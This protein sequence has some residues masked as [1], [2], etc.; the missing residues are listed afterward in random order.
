[1]PNFSKERFLFY[2]KKYSNILFK[3]AFITSL[4]GMF[5]FIADFGFDKSEYIQK[6]FNTYYFIVIALGI[7]ATIF[8]YLERLKKIKRS[9]IIFDVV[10]ILITLMIL[11]AHFLGVDAHK[12]ISFLYNDNW[13]KFAIILTFIREFSEK[14]INYKSTRLNPAQL[15]IASFL[16]IIFLGTLLLMLPNATYQGISFLDALFTSTSAVCVTGLIVV[17]TGSYF[18]TFGQSIILCLIQAGGIGIL[19]IAS[20]F[21]YF[22]KG[23]ATYENQ[24][25]LGDMTGANKLGEVFS[26]LKRILTI[27]FSIELFA[28]I[29]IYSSLDKNL[30]AS[31]FEKLFFSVFHAVSAFC[32]AGFSTLPNSLY[33]TGF[34]Y[35][36]MLQGI[37]ITAFILGGLGFPIVVNIIKYLKYFVSRKI[38]YFTG[39]KLSHKPWVLNLNSRITLVTTTVLTVVGT[40]LF[41]INEFNNTLAEHKG[42]GKFITA[43]FG[44]AT[45]RTAGF[46]T[47]DMT[48]LNFST[49]MMLFLLMWIGASPASTGGGIKTNTFAIATLNFFSLARGKSKIEVFRREIADISVRR[50]F[51]V[52]ALS[53]LVVGT[54]IIL[55]SIFDSDK[56]LID[57]AF[58][59]FS[60]YS[61]VGLSLGITSSLSSMSKLT[62]I[63]VMFI[64]R[65]SMLTLL[66]AVF[67]KIKHKNYKYP[68][69]ELTIN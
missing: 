49:V 51:A 1:M 26:T 7:I 61:T 43:L 32:N 55:I 12:H 21:S 28:A 62:I 25:T 58:E 19:T 42:V 69:E 45:P 57:I 40:I 9:V 24:L 14:S 39:K 2:N 36:Y 56:S 37:I 53:L 63:A 13:V 3:V 17:D 59:C 35:N 4:I 67:K 68:V 34:R 33:E 46:N 44:A 65:V 6:L 47:V 64:G 5:L 48:A 54:G 16:G 29:L 18:T 22:F 50:A 60:A 10:T 20:Y 8:R 66:I 11:Y 15:F 41:Y 31:F 38:F 27:T 23:G 52:I 30:F